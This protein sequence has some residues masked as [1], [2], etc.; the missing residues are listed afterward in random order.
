MS[1]GNENQP[2]HYCESPPPGPTHHLLHPHASLGGETSRRSPGCPRRPRSRA[3]QGKRGPDA[4][5]PKQGLRVT[6][7]CGREGRCAAA[8]LPVAGEVKGGVGGDE[9]ERKGRRRERAQSRGGGDRAAAATGLRLASCSDRSRVRLRPPAG[10][11]PSP[12]PQRAHVT[13]TE[14]P[15]G[16][17]RCGPGRA[18][19]A[20]ERTNARSERGRWAPAAAPPLRS[21]PEGSAKPPGL[22]W[23][24]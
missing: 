14:R 9:V 24:S 2:W 7:R 19:R 5:A 22:R 20:R 17:G 23:A 13:A 21:P 1:C 12:R 10:A 15:R 3:R 6:H 4:D 8:R 11:P 16:R 18:D